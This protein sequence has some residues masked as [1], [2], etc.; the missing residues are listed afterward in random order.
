M[1]R[2]TFIQTAGAAAA[3][4]A[5]TPQL[6]AADKDRKRANKGL[7]YKSV[8]FGGKLTILFFI[9]FICFLLYKEHQIVYLV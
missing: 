4:A 3:V 7:I 8:K 1:N 6:Q 9:L 2:R 5:T